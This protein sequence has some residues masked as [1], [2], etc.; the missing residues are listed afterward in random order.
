M[1]QNNAG[2]Q[3]PAG[4]AETDAVTQGFS[5]DAVHELEQLLA[6]GQT[7]GCVALVDMATGAALSRGSD[8][9]LS[10]LLDAP[11]LTTL[12]R[13]VCA[14]EHN[15]ISARHHLR[16]LCLGLGGVTEVAILMH[17][18]DLF[19]GRLPGSSRVL[20]LVIRHLRKSA[21][22]STEPM[23]VGRTIR[24][25]L[26]APQTL[27]VEAEAERQVAQSYS[28][29]TAFLRAITANF[30]QKT[31]SLGLLGR[32]LTDHEQI[33]AGDLFDVEGGRHLDHYRNLR[34]QEAYTL[35]ASAAIVGLAELFAGHLDIPD[36][37]RQFGFAGASYGKVQAHIGD[38]D[39]YWLR[40]PAY[41]ALDIPFDPDQALLL[42]KAPR[43]NPSL[44]WLP[45]DRLGLNLLRLRIGVLLSGDMR[46]EM[47]PFPQTHIEF[48]EIIDRL[49]A[50]PAEDLKARLDV[51]GFAPH[52]VEV[53]GIHQRCLEC[54]YYLPHRRWCDLPELPVPVEPDWWC[55]LWKI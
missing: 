37:L 41:P 24:S 1:N 20:S 38:R 3:P 46:T 44:D 9:R 22:A 19:I 5:A 40:V 43:I 25:E 26:A 16:R 8:D 39:F 36:I 14:P 47:Y 10:A 29:W 28:I 27:N 30:T 54:I 48:Q 53:D 7:S 33:L 17:D 21:A 32:T 4:G 13:A 49:M 42:I 2:T 35:D 52:P 50:L 11:G 55:R 51:G 31:P 6:Q 23:Q 15:S 12:T 18:C 34:P 45:L